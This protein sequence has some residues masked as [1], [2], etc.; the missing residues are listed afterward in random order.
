MQAEAK[1]KRDFFI[2]RTRADS[3]WAVWISQELEAAGYTTFLQ[4]R[5]ILPGDSF[6]AK[7]QE[8]A[9][10][11][12]TI[13]V[14][15][16]EYWQ[17]A[18]TQPEWQSAFRRGRLLP[19]RVERCE[20]PA[21]LAHYVYV[22]LVGKTPEQ[23]RQLLLEAVKHERLNPQAE[24]PGQFI[25]LAISVARLPVVNPLLIG[26]EAELKQLDE[27]W[28]DPAIRLACVVAFGGVGKTSLVIN[29]WHR[30]Q[31]PGAKRILG[32]SFYAQ[33]ETEDRQSSADSFFD[34]ALREWFGVSNPPADSWT[35]GEK[36]AELIRRERTLLILDGLEP[37]QFPPGAQVGRL[38]DPG[39]AALLKELAAQNPG[40]CV[41][42]SRLPLT[43][44]ED[45]GAAGA[46]TLDLDN[47]TPEAGGR[48]LAQLGVQ[49]SEEELR[50]ASQDFHNHALALTLLGNFLVK[51]R[52]GDVRQRDTVP[53]I[54]EEPKKGG[55]AQ[56]VLRQYEALFQGKPEL[57][58]L[59][60]MGLFDRPADNGALRILRKLDDDQWA[61]ALENLAE[62]RLIAYENPEGPLDC[63]PLV[64]AHFAKE[65]ETSD[66]EAFREAHSL[67]FEHYA[68]QAPY[69]PET[70]KAMTPL[71]Y[72]IYHGC[73][74]GRYSEALRDVGID[75]VLRGKEAFLVNKL[76]A[77]GIGLSLT[78][79]F[80]ASRW[81]TP[82]PALAPV[83]QAQVISLAGF[84]LRSLGR[85]KE[86]RE[87]LESAAGAAI[88]TKE[89]GNAAVWLG[90][91]SQLHLSLG[92]I[93]K[94]IDAAVRAVEA[95][96]RS[97][98]E[99]Q[100]WTKRAV[101]A[102]A[103]LQSGD[104]PAAARLFEQAR[105]SGLHEPNELGLFE[106]QRYL[107]TGLLLA[108]GQ[109]SEV[110]ERAAGAVERHEKDGQLLD[111]ALDHLYLGVALPQGSGESALHLDRAV[112]GLRGCGTIDYL[113]AGLL[114]RA[115]NSRCAN[116]FEKDQRDLDEVRSLATR[117]GMPL[118]LADCHLEQARLSL[119]LGKLEEAR[120]HYESAR[121]LID[122]TGYLRRSADLVNLNAQLVDTLDSGRTA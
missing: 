102:D 60:I 94:A 113:P 36:L 5:D 117:C 58:V 32:W 16:P 93:N 44:L 11:D 91:L 47:L 85:L 99:V 22:D 49:G 15:S 29:W 39:M 78:A 62:A 76:G 7:M 35:R 31:A 27:A 20:I 13:L 95:A 26:R 74:A 53:S 86:A 92:D 101:L 45:Y 14:M 9:E 68:K 17:A 69:R 112:T 107:Y 19:V 33:G 98:I 109:I 40:L 77:L 97:G 43:D 50:Q 73:K 104:L 116:D 34:H 89:W 110:I 79:N 41:C 80:F 12:C 70:L 10:W 46:L 66:P 52:G 61:E 106:P 51:R 42:T 84:A 54:L 108:Q 88:A 105:Q 83:D 21:L 71:F 72:A 81:K 115:V 59:R 111:A 100:K 56:R 1:K 90:N 28:S 55:D 120:A 6:V 8:G 122:E 4:D 118:H 82:I 3:K 23:A 64:R 114:A 65:Y 87:P 18:Y 96:D 2:S 38:R 103:L 48:Y 57:E 67:L 63:H 25:E 37:L 121:S 75:R 30:H 119:A 24:F